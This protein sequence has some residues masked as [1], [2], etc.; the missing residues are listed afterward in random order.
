MIEN[1]ELI[2]PHSSEQTH[3]FNHYGI[4]DV[5]LKAINENGCMIKNKKRITIEKPNVEI[6]VSQKKGCV[7]KIVEITAEDDLNQNTVID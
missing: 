5:E 7:P 6:H 1:F 4:F 2:T 3:Y